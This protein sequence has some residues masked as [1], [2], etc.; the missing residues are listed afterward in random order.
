LEGILTKMS[1]IDGYFESLRSNYFYDRKSLD[2]DEKKFFDL[3]VLPAVKHWIPDRSKLLVRIA[4]LKQVL[5]PQ[6][7]FY[8]Q[9]AMPLLNLLKS[10]HL[11]PWW[12]STSQ[13]IHSKGQFFIQGLRANFAPRRQLS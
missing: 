11:M 7:G 4:L 9:I 6:N 8:I 5:H 10:Y 3:M 13:P 1:L 12:D 2:D